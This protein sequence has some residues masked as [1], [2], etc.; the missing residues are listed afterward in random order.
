MKVEVEDKAGNS[1]TYSQSELSSKGFPVSFQIT[2]SPLTPVLSV[3]PPLRELSASGGTTSFEVKNAGGGTMSWTASVSDTWLTIVSGSSGVNSGTITVSCA[4]SSENKSAKIT[5]TAAGAGNSPQTV[6]VRNYTGDKPKY[7]ISGYVSGGVSGT[8]EAIGIKD[9]LITFSNGAGSTTTDSSGFYTKSVEYGWSGTVTPSLNNYTFNPSSRS[10]TNIA[11]NQTDQSYTG[12]MT[13]YQISGYVRDSGNSPMSNVTINF[14]N[15]GGSTA[16]N[17]SGY[18]AKVVSYGWSGTATPSK[19]GYSFNPPSIFYT[20]I[21]SNQ[22]DRNYTGT[23]TS[24]PN[25]DVSPTSLVFTKPKSSRSAN[26]RQD[27]VQ[28]SDTEQDEEP[29]EAV[30]ATGLIV[31]ESVEEYWK[32]HTPS[33]KY[34]LR[35]DLP[36]S[37]DWSVYDSPVKNQ[38]ICGSCWAFATIALIENLANQANLSVETDFTEQVLVSCLYQDRLEGRGCQGGWYWD[39]FDYIKKNGIPHESSYPYKSTW[40]VAWDI[41]CES[42]K[43]DPDFLVKI[44][45]HTPVS[46][47]WGKTNFTVQD[48]KG[49]LQDGPLCVAMYVPEGFSEYEGGIYDYNS[50]NVEWGHA[51]LLLGYDDATQCFKVKNSW[52]ESWGEGGYFRIAYNDVTDSIKFGSYAATASGVV[53]EKKGNVSQEITITN[54]GSADLLINTISK[55]KAWLGIVPQT[56][57]AISPGQSQKVAVSITDWNAVQANETGTIAIS[58][59][60]PDNSSVPVIVSINMPLQASSPIINI[61]PPFQSGIS[62]TDDKVS[63]EV[64]GSDGTT[65]FTVSNSGDGTMS[66]TAASNVSWL[67]IEKGDSGSDTGTVSLSYQANPN[68]SERT[69]TITVSASGALNSPQTVEIVQ[70]AAAAPPVVRLPLGDINKDGSVDLRDLILASQVRAGMNKTVRA[71]F[72]GSDADI[73]KDGKVGAEEEIYILQY[74]LYISQ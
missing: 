37:K 20:S 34:R 52:G 13:A 36:S 57:S 44:T 38:K 56:L 69:G 68:T 29:E 65:Y 19:G 42:K 15:Q 49:A 66:W 3:S 46:G 59:N 74:L 31:P 1:R 2:D 30:Y 14:D 67:K 9:V 25:I 4:A 45:N 7:N 39:G 61:S 72:I 41:N 58:S 55:D 11:S 43:A 28:V 50:G 62:V 48:L 32:T 23:S 73:N 54:T 40:L 5:V 35:K 8:G 47:L 16:T 53:L 6:E 71:D 27:S 10:Y 26:A 24:V 33:R 22:A 63:I 64:S 51:V 18:Y 70:A 60:D 17:D 21:A 12:E